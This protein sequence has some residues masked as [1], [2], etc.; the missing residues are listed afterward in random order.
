MREPENSKLNEIKIQNLMIH[1]RASALFGVMRSS[2]SMR[3]DMKFELGAIWAQP[4][5]VPG[6]L[7]PCRR[8]VWLQ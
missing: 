1:L 7:P 5:W 8:P 6:L 4:M 3:S 2:N